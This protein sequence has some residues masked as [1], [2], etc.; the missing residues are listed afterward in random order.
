MEMICHQFPL[1]LA[2]GLTMNKS[3]GQI[4]SVVEVDLRNDVFVFTD[5]ST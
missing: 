2:F 3:L 1:Q 5:S 4:M